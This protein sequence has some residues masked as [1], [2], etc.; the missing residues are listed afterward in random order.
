MHSGSS[1][2]GA[3]ASE[4]H[5]ALTCPVLRV[6]CVAGLAGSG[7][8]LLI[9]DRFMTE[10][11]DRPLLEQN[12]RPA[13]ASGDSYYWS[14][15]LRSRAHEVHAAFGVR[16]RRTTGPNLARQEPLNSRAATNR[17]VQMSPPLPEYSWHAPTNT[18]TIHPLQRNA[19]GPC[20]SSG[21]SDRSRGSWIG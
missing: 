19:E 1:V 9:V 21:E 17:D 6:S 20:H 15:T 13:P 18:G 14:N 10:R 7:G 2:V 3:P 4:L 12:D 5:T 16:R 11:A 8:L